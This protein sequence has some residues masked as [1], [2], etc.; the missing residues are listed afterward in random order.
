MPTTRLREA[1]G[2][3]GISAIQLKDVTVFRLE[4]IERESISRR[5][6]LL[7]AFLSSQATEKRRVPEPFSEE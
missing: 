2:P 3:L 7:T 1:S 5:A 4:D 6:T